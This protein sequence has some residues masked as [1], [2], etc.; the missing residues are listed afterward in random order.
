MSDVP[1][2]LVQARVVK[3]QTRDGSMTLK[4]DVAVG[5][6]VVVNLYMKLKVPRV[7]AVGIEHTEVIQ[8]ATDGGWFPFECLELLAEPVWPTEGGASC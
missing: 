5:L 2:F 8:C 4:S 7:T 6:L 1:V 3:L